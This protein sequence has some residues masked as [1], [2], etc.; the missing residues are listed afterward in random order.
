MSGT[1][2]YRLTGRL[3]GIQTQSTGPDRPAHSPPA[4]S[5]GISTRQSLD[6]RAAET[7]IDISDVHDRPNG[8]SLELA[9]MDRTMVKTAAAAAIEEEERGQSATWLLQAKS[10]AR[11]ASFS[12]SMRSGVSWHWTDVRHMVSSWYGT[13]SLNAMIVVSARSWH[14]EAALLL[15]LS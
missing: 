5:A 2:F 1:S 7:S 3:Q 9:R 8:G 6:N 15:D 13:D 4:A 12:P 10:F 11:L 14:D